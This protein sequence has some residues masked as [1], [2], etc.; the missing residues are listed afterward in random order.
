M[1]KTI[2][3]LPITNKKKVSITKNSYTSKIEAKNEIKNETFDFIDETQYIKFASFFNNTIAQDEI[4]EAYLSAYKQIVKTYLQAGKTNS[5]YFKTAEQLNTTFSGASLLK[6]GD[7]FKLIDI[8]GI[9]D[10]LNKRMSDNPCMVIDTEPNQQ[11]HPLQIQIIKEAFLLAVRT[12]IVDYLLRNFPLTSTF[13]NV[14]FHE[15]D[16]SYADFIAQTFIQRI[17]NYESYFT[18]LIFYLGFELESELENGKSFIDPITNK[19]IKFEYSNILPYEQKTQ[20]IKLYIQILVNEEIL[21]ISETFNKF[22]NRSITQNGVAIQLSPKFQPLDYLLNSFNLFIS[23]PSTEQAI[24]TL[25]IKPIG[26]GTFFY[27]IE[28]TSINS[29]TAYLCI[30]RTTTKYSKIINLGN[31]VRLTKEACKEALLIS[32]EFDLLF[33]YSLNP[34]KALNFASIYNI[35]LCSRLY[36]P[37]NT[38][39]EPPIRTAIRIHN[40]SLSEQQPCD[41]ADLNFEFTSLTAQEVSKIVLQTTVDII[42]GLEETYDPNIVIS[43]LM[44]DGAEALGAPNISIIPYSSYLMFTP[45]PFGPMI[46]VSSPLGYV[47][48][49]ISALEA[50]YD[51]KGGSDINFEGSFD[52]KNPFEKQDC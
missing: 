47:Y 26:I 20:E 24:D 22:F 46:P 30:K 11:A 38:V 1:I 44:K 28:S 50:A 19:E 15:K 37:T 12:H 52:I 8:Q 3:E 7:F 17:E 27:L 21:N 29:G 4:K 43:K 39:F 51:Q 45:I 14:K 36:E 31:V 49:G 5:I 10:G 25:F 6:N 32:S 41:E 16:S 42:K 34:N 18:S 35:L 2:E 23:T 40:N 13:D 9:K 33:N 48:W